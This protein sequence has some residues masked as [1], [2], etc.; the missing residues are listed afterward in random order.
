MGGKHSRNKGNAF[1]RL[2]AKLILEALSP[3]QPG[4]R[5][6]YR[7][8]L[9]GG[10]PFAARGDLIIAERLQPYFPFCVEAK[11]HKTWHPGAFMGATPRE[12][13]KGWIKQTLAATKACEGPIPQHP[14]LAM[15]GNLTGAFAAL[16]FDDA[17]KLCPDLLR[18]KP[19]LHFYHGER[20]IMF[21]LPDF[22]ATWKR[23]VQL[24]VQAEALPQPAPRISRKKGFTK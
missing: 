12:S 11:H 20:W 1:E 3:L 5:D 8:P 15:N 10:H 24:Q 21:R 18:L 22:L 19:Q 6:V 4:K 16:L 14:L 17:R 23:K 2:L 9:S 13:E 7:T